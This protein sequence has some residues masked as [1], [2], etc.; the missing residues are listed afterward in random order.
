MLR[1]PGRKVVANQLIAIRLER[2]TE[3]ADASFT[4]LDIQ[5]TGTIRADSKW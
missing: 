3:L 1:F 4:Q 2:A 5:R